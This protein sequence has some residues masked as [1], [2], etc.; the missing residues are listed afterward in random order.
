MLRIGRKC[1][2]GKRYHKNNVIKTGYHKDQL[3]KYCLIKVYLQWWASW[4][5]SLCKDVTG[6]ISVLVYG[7]PVHTDQYLHYRCHSQTICKE[8]VVSFLFSRAYPSFTNKDDL[9]KEN[10]RIKQVL[11]ENGYQESIISKI[12]K[13]ITYNDSLSQSQQCENV[14]A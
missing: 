2:L 13:K 12:F 7:K 10:A 9:N 3:L 8:S 4:T 5:T 11:K 14:V 6:K 1:L